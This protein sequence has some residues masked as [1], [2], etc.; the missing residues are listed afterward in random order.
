[1]F[2]KDQVHSYHVSLDVLNRRPNVTMIDAT[3][4]ATEN[5][6]KDCEKMLD[7]F[8]CNVEPGTIRVNHIFKVGEM[9]RKME[10]QCYTHY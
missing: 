4:D 1:M 10:M 5:I 3:I 7:T 2:H 9:D 8:Y 6:Y